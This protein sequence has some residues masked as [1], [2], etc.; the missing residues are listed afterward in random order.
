M[1]TNTISNVILIQFKKLIILVSLL[2][3]VLA[4]DMLFSQVNSSRVNPERKKFTQIVT[5]HKANGWTKVLELEELLLEVK[6]TDDDTLKWHIHATLAMNYSLMGEYDPAIDHIYRGLEV[7]KKAGIVEG[8]GQMY[9]SKAALMYS[10]KNYRE[11]INYADVVLNIGVENNFP[12]LQR[13]AYEIKG[14]SY[15]SLEKID[16]AILELRKTLLPKFD[17][18]KDYITYSNLAVAFDKSNQLD[19]SFFYAKK[20]LDEAPNPYYKTSESYLVMADY[21]RKKD[22]LDSAEF[23]FKKSIAAADSAKN[24][25]HF[26]EAHK[27]LAAFFVETNQKNQAIFQHQKL[28]GIRENYENKI[29]HDKVK[30]LLIKEDIISKSEENKALERKNKIALKNREIA[31]SKSMVFL[32]G[33]IIAVLVITILVW[34]SYLNRKKSKEKD[35]A[36]AARSREL[37]KMVLEISDYK[38]KIKDIIEHLKRVNKKADETLI[39]KNKQLIAT[40]SAKLQEIYQSEIHDKLEAENK[41]FMK[42][43]GSLYT[44]LSNNDLKLCMYIRAGLSSKQIAMLKDITPGAVNVSRSRIRKK[45]DG[46]IPDDISLKKFLQNF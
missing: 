11:A 22:L 42:N 5:T 7:T 18:T 26:I 31:E 9:R 17:S 46:A 1:L 28:D 36:M 38:S 24:D 32:L 13:S 30:Y 12:I 4:P 3:T 25:L 39:K 21:Y 37:T 19:S 34:L 44:E 10:T 40:L 15:M 2:I 41:N 23:Y 8:T 16:S 29:L 27:R 35:R 45:M 14:I 43:L 33:L 6:N 20:A